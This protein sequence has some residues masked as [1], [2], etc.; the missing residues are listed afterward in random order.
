[1]DMMRMFNM[2]GGSFGTFGDLV[3]SV[4]GLLTSSGLE[5]VV[6]FVLLAGFTYAGYLM[7]RRTA[8]VSLAFAA[9]LAAVGAAMFSLGAPAGYF[10][11]NAGTFFLGFLY[12]VWEEAYHRVSH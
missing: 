1:M 10:V 5:L 8:E 12:P 7:G 9:V 11:V 6:N 4:S 2:G 3:A